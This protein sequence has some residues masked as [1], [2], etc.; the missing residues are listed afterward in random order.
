M[1]VDA[2]PLYVGLPGFPVDFRM[3]Q[4]FSNRLLVFLSRILG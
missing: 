1:H 4:P 2:E 3:E